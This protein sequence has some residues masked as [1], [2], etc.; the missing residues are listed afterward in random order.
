MP[1]FAANLTT[2]FNDTDFLARFA[3][4]R[5]AGFEGVEFLFPYTHPPAAVLAQLQRHRLELVQ[6][7]LPPGDWDAGDRGLAVDPARQDAF[8][9]SV[10]QALDYARAVGA[11]QL[12]C[13]A[14]LVPRGLPLAT[15]HNCYVANLRYAAG[16]FAAHGIRLMIEPINTFDMPGYFL[17]GSAQAAAIIAEVGAPNLYLQFDLYHMQ[18]MEG[19]LADSITRLLP[20]IRHMQLADVPGRHEPG[21][22]EIDWRA[23][24]AH[25]D[26]SGYGGWIGCEYFPKA[27][28]EAGLGWRE[29]LV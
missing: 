28:T 24:F 23:L 19:G 2:L 11:T 10:A 3:S 13:M 25:I 4:A 27:G 12:H 29:Q 7:N 21:T 5:A 1:R 8:R 14:G 22:G 9:A 17:H 18:R 15:A 20:L 16:I 26:G 6:F